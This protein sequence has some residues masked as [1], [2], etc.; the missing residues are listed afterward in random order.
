M[1]IVWY[2]YSLKTKLILRNNYKDNIIHIFNNIATKFIINI[3]IL[4]IE[5]ENNELFAIKKKDYLGKELLV[6][7]QV[8]KNQMFD[9]ND[10]I[11]SSFEELDLD[12]LIEELEK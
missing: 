11:V 5:L 2:I 10:F 4:T 3:Y 8:R 1:V 12:K 7:G 9:Q 6:K